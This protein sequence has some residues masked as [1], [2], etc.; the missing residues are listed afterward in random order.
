M[1]WLVPPS[2]YTTHKSITAAT[3]HNPIAAGTNR[4]QS[5]FV[6]VLFCVVWRTNGGCS[7]PSEG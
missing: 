1:F 5:L 2:F 6:Q 4:L 3:A 7:R